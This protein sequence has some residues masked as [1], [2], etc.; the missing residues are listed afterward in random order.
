MQ[1]VVKK[2]IPEYL[3]YLKKACYY[4]NKEAK[5]EYGLLLEEGRFC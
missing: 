3:K 1:L 4:N 2:N 5:Y